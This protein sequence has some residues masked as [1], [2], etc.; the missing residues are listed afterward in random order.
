MSATVILILHNIY[1]T[2][3]DCYAATTYKFYHNAVHIYFF[4]G[5]NLRLSEPVNMTEG[6]VQNIC[7]TVESTTQPR[8]RVV[9]V[10]L[11]FVSKTLSA[12]KA[13]SQPN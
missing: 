1:Y 10:S 3:S 12:S 2:G 7:V 11:T 6:E 13:S 9:P 5:V 4:T 8:E